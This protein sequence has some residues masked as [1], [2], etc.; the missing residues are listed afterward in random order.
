MENVAKP[1]KNPVGRKK[2]DYGEK[3]DRGKL[4]DADTILQTWPFD[5]VLRAARL[6]ARRKKM[7]HAEYVLKKMED[8]EN[9]N[10]EAYELRKAEEFYKN[11][12]RM[13]SLCCQFLHLS[14]SL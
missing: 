8:E 13:F 7:V 1:P 6:G 11:H 2:K 10:A 12:K 14:L 3:S 4:M 5:A 9:A